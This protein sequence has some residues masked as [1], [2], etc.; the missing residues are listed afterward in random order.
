MNFPNPKILKLSKIYDFRAFEISNFDASNAVKIL[1]ILTHQKSKIF[2]CF[3]FERPKIHRIFE[4]FF[5]VE[6]N[7][8]V[9]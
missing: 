6:G 7:I 3:A 2:E 1:L 8:Y 9:S 4:E 5:G